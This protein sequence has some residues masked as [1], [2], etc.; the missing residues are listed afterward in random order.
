MCDTRRPVYLDGRIDKRGFLEFAR[1]LR[2]GPGG[3]KGVALRGWAR[4]L[5]IK[6]FECEER[7]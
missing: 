6:S 3:K 4:S 5:V 7:W 2:T 1:M